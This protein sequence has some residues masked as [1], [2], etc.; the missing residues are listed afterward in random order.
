MIGHQ[1]IILIWIIK[2]IIL[3]FIAGPEI[4]SIYVAGAGS[5]EGRITLTP[6]PSRP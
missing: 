6:T 1:L 3:V 5:S 2:L 4:V